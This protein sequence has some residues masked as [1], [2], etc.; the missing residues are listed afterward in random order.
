MSERDLP[1]ERA[2]FSPFGCALLL[3]LLPVSALAA[4]AVKGSDPLTWSDVLTVL[5]LVLVNGV[6]AMVEAAL[7]TVR[8]SRIEQ[9]VEEG[10]RAAIQVAN[11][12]DH[13]TRM[14]A[15]LQVGITVVTLFSAGAAAEKAVEPTAEWL[16]R[17]APAL[18]GAAHAVALV[19]VVLSVSLLTL[20]VGEITPKSIAVQKAEPL[21]LAS[22]LPVTVL[23][24]ILSPVV[25]GVTAASNLLVR[26]FGG[27]A[28]FHVSAMSEEELKIMVEQSEEHGVIESA[29]KEMIHSIFELADTTVHRIMTPRLDITA[30]A[31]DSGIP[32]LV[33]FVRKS[34]HSRLPVY[35]GDLDHIVGVVHVKDALE[36]TQSGKAPIIRDLMRP[37]FFIPDNKRIDDL[38]ADFRVNKNHIAVVRDEYGTVTGIVT[39]EDLLEEIVGEIQDEYDAEEPSLVQ[40]DGS[41]MLVD[42]KVPLVDLCERLGLEVPEEHADTVGGFLFGLLGHQPV[43]GETITWERLELKVE[44]TDGRRVQRVRIVKLAPDGCAADAEAAD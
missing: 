43:V 3:L 41:T 31:A 37:P 42:A 30:I 8:R 2:R 6:F 9:L 27:T 18:H 33:S 14:L 10:N 21:A 24:T 1:H 13:P 29:E 38:L 44:Q 32:E 34:G 36:A 7:L 16:I 11:L 39:L 17:V 28:S 5:G 25:A 35:D 20:I 40:V 23:Q 22:A 26:P 4:D 12:L 15:T 19:V